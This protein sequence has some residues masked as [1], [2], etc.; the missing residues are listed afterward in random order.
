MHFYY[1][2][3]AVRIETGSGRTTQRI[4]LD[5][6]CRRS[7]V[8]LPGSRANS[9]D[10]SWIFGKRGCWATGIWRNSRA[11][12]RDV[13]Y[14]PKSAPFTTRWGRST[15]RYRSCWLACASGYLHLRVNA[16]WIK[17]TMEEFLKWRREVESVVLCYNY[18]KKNK[19]KKIWNKTPQKISKITL[20]PTR[21]VVWC[22][23]LPLEVSLCICW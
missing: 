2:H 11:S 8:T 20:T 18:Y 10:Q 4:S 7:D 1:W 16:N 17:G 3:L 9:Q 14:S 12:K 19:T 22:V 13:R 23:Y 15:P 5:R 21:P 6:V